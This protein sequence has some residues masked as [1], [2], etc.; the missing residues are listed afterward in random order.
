[1]IGLDT[2]ILVRY[3]TQDDPIQSP[4]ANEIIERRLTEANPGFVSIVAMAEIVWVL[5][6]AYG[7][8]AREIAAAVERILQTEVLAVENEQ[9]VF[10]ALIAL[11]AGQG[12]FSDA[13]IAAL[14]ARMGCS[15]TL[16]FDQKA[17]RLPGFELP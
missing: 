17:L 10:T 15:L 9:E 8:G 16:T 2:N 4:K 7:L 12:S 1:M 14:G 11:R 5:D 3:L 13:L 6:R